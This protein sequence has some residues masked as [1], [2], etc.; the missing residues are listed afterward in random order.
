LHKKTIL[1]PFQ[2]KRIE[3]HENRHDAR[4][5]QEYKTKV[6]LAST[7]MGNFTHYIHASWDIIFYDD[8]YAE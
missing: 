6:L 4:M 3:W 1:I 8:D 5:P 7:S 2:D